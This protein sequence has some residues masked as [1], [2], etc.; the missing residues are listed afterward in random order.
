MLKID[1]D[2]LKETGLGNLPT[3][4]ANAF[5]K[6][7][8]ETL[9]TRV[10]VAFADRMSNEQLDEFERFFEARD[11]AGAF[12]WLE[13]NFPDYKA[14][15]QSRFDE[16]KLEVSRLAPEIKALSASDPGVVALNE[17]GRE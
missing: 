5:L 7:V 17:R 4:E 11:D 15:V 8:Y 1:H 6:H 10:G 13:S 3:W 2:F 16:L 14:I 9:E 12:A